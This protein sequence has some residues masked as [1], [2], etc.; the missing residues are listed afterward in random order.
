MAR[1]AILSIKILADASKAARELDKTSG[2]TSKWAGGM[3][4]AGA[5]AAVGLAAVGAVVASGVKAAAEDA[6]Q[7]AVLAKALKNTTGATDAQVA[8]TEDFISK[9]ALATGVAD[10]QL[11]PAMGNLARATGSVEESQKAMGLALDISAATGK[12]VESVSKALAKGYAGQ[13]SSLGK[14]VPGMDKAVL[15]S[16][17]MAKISDELKKKVGGTAAAAAETAAGKA[18]RMAVAM[19]E[20]K[21]GI[22]A[23]LLP[24]I[25]KLVGKLS[26]VVSWMTKNQ[27]T[28]TILLG[29]FAALAAI[30]VTV[31]AVTKAYVAISRIVKT[32][33]LAWN[34]AQKALNLSLLSNPV[35]LIVAA[36]VALVAIIVLAYKKSATFRKI[37]DGAFRAVKKAAQAAWDWIKKNWPLLL[38]IITGPIGLAIRW[39]VNNWDRIKGAISKVWDWIK[40]NA[41]KPFDAVRTAAQAVI[42][43]LRDKLGPAFQRVGDIIDSA[44]RPAA[45]I[46][47]GIKSA[48]QGVIDAVGWLID[49]LSH[50][51][52]PKVPD[53]NPFSAA[54]A[55][56]R[57]ST[58]VAGTR[59][60]ARPTARTAGTTVVVNISGALDPDAT[61]RAIRR[62]LDRADVRAGRRTPYTRGEWATP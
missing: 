31:N 5:A 28:V 36:I 53:L 8:A 19:D 38:A 55:P 41:R 1:S 35:F 22:G 46:F 52:F 34:L 24:I 6:Q 50:V 20:L 4:K 37:V 61:A 43:W 40:T 44:I 62:I 10:D 51:H 49:K 58:A 11:R 47:D 17:D 16:G 39:I 57:A 18:Q 21:E 33:T 25:D 29:A 54:P 45:A 60:V 30:I 14:L 56:A 27:S 23:A 26:S 3:K 13:T 2:K 15:A 42:D 48:I 59:A 9:T 7:Q 32:V 12:D